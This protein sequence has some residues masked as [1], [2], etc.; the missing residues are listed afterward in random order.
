MKKQL[1][2]LLLTFVTVMLAA[3]QLARAFA[4]AEG[5]V[6]EDAFP[7]WSTDARYVAF[8]ENGITWATPAGSGTATRV[9]PGKPRGFQPGG[10]KLLLQ[11]GG[12][13]TVTSTTGTPIRGFGGID[14]TW[15]P[16]GS[17]IAYIDEGNLLV[18]FADSPK[19]TVLAAGVS[20]P[21]W[22]VTGPVWSPDGT[23]LVIASGSSLV[24]ANAD[25]SGKKVLFSGANQS[26]NPTWSPDGSLIAFERNAGPHW[27]IWTVRP[28]GSDARE[29]LGGQTSDYRYPQFSPVSGKLAFISDRQ[30]IPG[31]ATAYQ[32][33]LYDESIGAA[34][35]NKLVDD[36]HPFSPPAW[37]PTAAQ[38]AV[39]A[40]QECLRWGIYVVRDVPFP[41]VAHRR[42]NECRFTGTS[43]ADMLKGT[44]YHDIINGNG[45]N[46]VISG[47]GGNDK[48][49]GNNGND[50]ILG[51]PGNDVILGGPG[52]DRVYGGPGNDVIIPGY[53]H[54]LIDCGPGN[55]TVLGTGPLDHVAK[56]CE[57]V[58]R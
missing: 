23:R 6:P 39:A 57:R 42:S 53:G 48:I 47:E 34:R 11:D 29:I 8:E 52:N 19:S 15:S 24:L 14:P 20:P 28:D 13:I 35:P 16:D 27:Q 51:G 21:S 40:G 9:A 46:D 26:V 18:Q 38:I 17:R 58:R 30:H 33:A 55:D 32:Y 2:V 50:T 49:A 10:A 4:P 44:P 12:G 25:G 22:D 1:G 31:G 7:A 54:D 3:G 45:G 56:N 36:V 37:S 5:G 43:G 41:A